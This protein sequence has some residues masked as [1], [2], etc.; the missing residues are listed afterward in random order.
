[1]LSPRMELTA[2]PVYKVTVKA[3]WTKIFAFVVYFGLDVRSRYHD[4]VFRPSLPLAINF[5]FGLLRRTLPC[6][7]YC[8]L[9]KG[10]SQFM[11][12]RYFK[13]GI[14]CGTGRDS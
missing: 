9:W 5:A 6:I 3:A 10:G 7:K 11:V 14:D 8:S 1:M 12:Q 2:S 13:L 4:L